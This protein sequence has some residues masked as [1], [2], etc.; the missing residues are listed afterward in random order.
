[1]FRILIRTFPDYQDVEISSDH[2]SEYERF[3]NIFMN[4]VANSSSY[5]YIDDSNTLRRLTECLKEN[6]RSLANFCPVIFDSVLCFKQTAAGSV[7]ESVCPL[8]HAVFNAPD[9]TAKKYCLEDGTWYKHPETNK[10]W[11]DYTDCVP[12]NNF[13]H[14]MSILNVVGLSMSLV[15]L[16]ISLCIF[17]SFR[18]LNCGRITMHKNL[19]MSFI[20]CN[21]AWLVYFFFI[22][23]EL[24]ISMNPIWCQALH[25]VITYFTLSTY[26]WML[27]EGAYLQLLLLDAFH[28]DKKR[29]YGLV[30]LGWGVPLILVI[31]YYG[32]VYQ[33]KNE[34]CWSDFG[35]ANWLLVVPVIIIIILNIVFLSNVIRM[36]RAKLTADTPNH[37]ARRS[38]KYRINETTMKQAKAALFLIPI[39]GINY[40]LLPIRPDPGSTS[41]IFEHLYDFLSTLS[42][43]FQGFFVSLLLCFTNSEV[44]SL[45][46]QRWSQFSASRNINLSLSNL[47][48]LPLISK[49][50]AVTEC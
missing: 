46:R 37:T 2:R 25:I 4:M 7:Q 33:M 1:M 15:L 3:V 50:E 14:Y 31:F 16:I 40:L 6:T 13:H 12:V 8:D 18:S 30:S 34:M 48:H 38:T 11:S 9:S 35:S 36:L 26:F 41:K 5:Y 22:F 19:F 21:T 17:F 45:A 44:L 27:C 39:L 24:F 43:S 49:S 20:L 29:I 32:I 28:S 42:S 23:E 10:T 47:A